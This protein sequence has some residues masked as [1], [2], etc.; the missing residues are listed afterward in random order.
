MKDSSHKER[1]VELRAQGKSFATIAE[2]IGVSKPTLITWSRELG[3]RVQNLR[4][5]NDEALIEKYRLTK[6]REIKTLSH[7]LEAVEKEL[8]TR[9]L[10][11]IPTEKLYGVLFK[12]MDETRRG[13]QS[14]T[15]TQTEDGIDLTEDMVTRH[16]W[17]A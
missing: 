13:H 16:S 7:Q 5:I 14:L 10:A 9:S 15:F 1:F 4:A 2:E 3:E 17:A 11:D 12:L 6:E 8:A